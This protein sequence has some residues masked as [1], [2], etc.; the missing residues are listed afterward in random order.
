MKNTDNKKNEENEHNHTEEGFCVECYEEYLKEEGISN[1]GFYIN[2]DY[3][4]DE[5]EI[6]IIEVKKEIS[7]PFEVRVHK[8]HKNH[9]DVEE[10]LS[11]YEVKSYL[12]HIPP[13]EL[14]NDSNE[15]HR[16]VETKNV[17]GDKVKDDFQHYVCCE[18]T[19]YPEEETKSVDE[20]VKEDEKN[21]RDELFQKYQTSLDNMLEEIVEKKRKEKE[22]PKLLN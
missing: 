10:Y 11:S 19:F 20:E 18:G 2:D 7:I 1:D 16:V 9:F 17:S 8:D 22:E 21:E 6:M 5:D 13:H 15:Y 12:E 3:M 14:I 4:T